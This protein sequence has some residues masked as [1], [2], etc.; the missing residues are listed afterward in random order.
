MAAQLYLVLGGDVLLIEVDLAGRGLDEAVDHLQRG[1]L[2]A[3]G[4]SDQNGHLALLDLKG[5]VVQDL[6]A[7]IG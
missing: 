3:A 2:A 1:G 5:Q 6:L 7:A 4:R